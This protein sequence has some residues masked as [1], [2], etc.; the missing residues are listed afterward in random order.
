MRLLQSPG[1]PVVD[2]WCIDFNHHFIPNMLVDI[3]RFDA[4]ARL[5]CPDSLRLRQPGQ[6]Q[7][8]CVP[9]PF[10]AG[11]TVAAQSGLHF[12]I[13]HVLNPN[14]PAGDSCG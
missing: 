10:F 8:G 2:M 14:Q 3:T 1:L 13:W 9:H 12:A 5:Q 4:S 11:F 7:E 6:L